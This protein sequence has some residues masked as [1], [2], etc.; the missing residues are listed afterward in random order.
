M[1]TPIITTLLLLA[2]SSFVKAQTNQPSH[3]QPDS[4]IKI[5]PFGDGRHTGYLYTI[6]G[7]LQTPEDV[8]I[9][10]LAYAP[11]A[12]EYHL[13]KN[14]ITW[15]YVSSTGFVISS[16]AAVFEFVH[17]NKMAGETTALVNGQPTF[18]YQ[19][20]SLTGAYIFTGIATAFLT[21]AIINFV[22]AAKHSDKAIKAYNH[23]FE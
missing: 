21:S 10:L 16:I 12:E 22:H 15:S 5:I 8:Q 1:K 3:A 4:V 14:D 13:A 11:S 23:R 19:H 18:I 2:L 6:G 7:K 9:K 20:H 17:N